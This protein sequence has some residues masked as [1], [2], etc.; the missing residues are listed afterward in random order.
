[1]FAALIVAGLS[2]DRA[3][4]ACGSTVA[5]T[6]KK[7][8]ATGT[9]D[10]ELPQVSCRANSKCGATKSSGGCGT[11][12][13]K[14]INGISVGSRNS[15]R[16][17]DRRNLSDDLETTEKTS[18]TS[19][20]RMEDLLELHDLQL[21]LM[22]KSRKNHKRRRETT[23]RRIR[24]LSQELTETVAKIENFPFPDRLDD[25][26]TVI[27]DIISGKLKSEFTVG[28]GTTPEQLLLNIQKAQLAKFNEYLKKTPPEGTKTMP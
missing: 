19:T 8:I 5:R 4:G 18:G 22:Q 9:I 15:S 27:G 14:R 12:G 2:A 1:M 24:E 26:E 25:M 13:I 28:Y 10:T 23:E 6:Q 20:V 7:I 21:D 17:R 16:T 11:S 3:L